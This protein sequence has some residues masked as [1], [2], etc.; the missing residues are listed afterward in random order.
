M[1][2]G[3]ISQR[4]R[5]Q[6]CKIGVNRR[7]TVLCVGGP[8]SSLWMPIAAELQDRYEIIIPELFHPDSDAFAD[9]NLSAVE[10]SVEQLG[11]LVER[12]SPEPV[13]VVS[14]SQGTTLAEWLVAVAPERFASAVWLCGVPRQWG[15]RSDSTVEIPG[16]SNFS[17]LFSAAAIRLNAQMERFSR[18][19][20]RVAALEAP[21]RLAKRFGLLDP[22]TADDSFNAVVEE[23]L[24]MDGERYKNYTEALSRVP[25]KSPPS[26]AP[27]RRLAVAGERDFFVPSPRIRQAAE[28]TRD[29]EFFEIISGTHYVP[30]EYGELTA[31]KLDDFFKR[32]TST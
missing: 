21:A 25:L 12:E 23:F 29:C 6:V 4:L 15:R 9:S 30:V 20:E 28:T 24:S 7:G 26:A 32:T 22:H 17:T 13:H 31:L 2:R 5:F 27:F 14:W 16:A 1:F 10:A 19:R 18:L 3:A 8:G 11:A